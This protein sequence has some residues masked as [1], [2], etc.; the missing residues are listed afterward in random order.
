MKISIVILT[1]GLL[2]PLSYA[3]TED[4]LDF[5]E[6]DAAE[7]QSTTAE[8]PHATPAIAIGLAV[9]GLT[10]AFVALALT[11]WR[12]GTPFSYTLGKLPISGRVLVTFFVAIL[13]LVHIFALTEVYLQTSVNSSST[14][15]YFSYVPLAKLVAMTHAHLFG[16]AV[17]YALVAGLFLF[18]RVREVLKT[19]ILSIAISGGL[20][21][22]VS[23]WLI[24]YASAKFEAL[25]I[26]S[27]AMA[28]L[29]FLAMVLIILYE[30]WFANISRNET[31]EETIADAL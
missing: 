28:A 2:I 15:E 26:L 3:Q 31:E 20:W 22:T 1:L 5:G 24:K 18:T 10:M 6:V 4:E 9:V 16:H 27:G 13:G 30:V 12:V 21:D 7:V 8:Y 17:M 23:W 11:R 14:E 29:G 25:S 19:L